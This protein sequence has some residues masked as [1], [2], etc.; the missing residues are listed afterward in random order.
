M[1]S[2]TAGTYA[3]I[4]SAINSFDLEFA[5]YI[6]SIRTVATTSYFFILTHFADVVAI[7]V[8]LGLTFLILKN[9]GKL[10]DMI[11]FCVCVFGAG[12]SSEFFK[13]LFQRARPMEA[14]YFEPTFSFPS[15]HATIALAM[16]GFLAF[17]I[18]KFVKNKSISV[19][20]VFALIG[21]S[22]LI[23]MSRLYLGVHY[24]SD[25]VGG[26]FIALLWLVFSIKLSKV[27]Q[28]GADVKRIK[29]VL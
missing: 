21:L 10:R 2:S 15:T 16:Y 17:L 8:V 5:R 13:L 6:A 12:I 27:I 11:S 22:L 9:K 1:L 23:G 28:K 7:I 18:F 19:P 29:D 25:V 26:F 24:L 20:I 3:I 4:N 14:V